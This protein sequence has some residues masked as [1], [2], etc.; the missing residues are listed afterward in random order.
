MSL[1][2]LSFKIQD[3]VKTSL[4]KP[5]MKSAA[6]TTLRF[7]AEYW[8]EKLMEERFDPSL[9][10]QYVF[11]PRW[12]IYLR[13]IKRFQGTG[14]G[15]KALLQ[16]KGRSLRFARHQF[17]I[18]ATERQ[19][20]V[21]LRMPSYFTDRKT[22]IV[23]ENGKRKNIRHQPDMVKELTQTT[24]ANVKQIDKRAT[25]VYLAHFAGNDGS[26]ASIGAKLDNNDTI[27]LVIT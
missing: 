12:Q 2:V 10:N 18:T 19:A 3:G 7:A 24:A 8:H 16:L 26:W 13:I 11:E 14:V 21:T 15:K 4:S 9:Q 27:T 25:E 1:I 5:K 20:T 22:G 23:Y 17:K 6:R